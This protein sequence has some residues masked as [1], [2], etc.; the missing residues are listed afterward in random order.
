MLK[1]LFVVWTS[2]GSPS[3]INIVVMI[4]PM[5]FGCLHSLVPHQYGGKI[6]LDGLHC[7][8][9]KMQYAFV[10]VLHAS[11]SVVMATLIVF[12]LVHPPNELITY[13]EKE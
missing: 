5:H 10:E 4:L 2:L 8:V 7:R 6:Q 11:L 3:L 1:R 9:Y 13:F 12:W